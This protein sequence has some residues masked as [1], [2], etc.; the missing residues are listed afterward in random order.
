MADKLEEMR[1]KL[2]LVVSSDRLKRG[3]DLGS[4]TDDPCGL[5]V[6]FVLEVCIPLEGKC[7]CSAHFEEWEQ[8]DMKLLD[9]QDK[10]YFVD[11]MRNCLRAGDSAKNLLAAVRD[12]EKYVRGM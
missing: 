2:I 1:N 4:V 8:K 10:E 7:V 12:M 5:H 11:K 3:L 9:D 6:I